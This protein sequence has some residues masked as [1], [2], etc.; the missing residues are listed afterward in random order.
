[1]E[2]TIKKSQLTEMKNMEIIDWIWIFVYF[3][4]NLRLNGSFD[5]L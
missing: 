5:K 3:D 1:M 2:R 4:F